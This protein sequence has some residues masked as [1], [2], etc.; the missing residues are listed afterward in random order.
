MFIWVGLIRRILKFLFFVIAPPAAVIF[1]YEAV[2]AFLLIII[3]IKV[4]LPFVAGFIGYIIADFPNHRLHKSYVAAHEL[5]HAI[6]AKLSGF[7]INKISITGTGGHV[8][9]NGK[10]KFTALAPYLIPLYALLTM[11]LFSLILLKWNFPALKIIA[12]AVFGF[13]MA[14]HL[15]NTFRSIYQEKQTDLRQGGGVIFSAILIILVNSVII[16]LSFEFLYPESI[17]ILD[18]VKS[19][20]FKTFDFWIFVIKSLF[21]LMVSVV[22]Y[23]KN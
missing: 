12:T 14:L 9:T 22:E 5:T 3:N 17:K 2:K 19:V 18:I 1:S 16:V 20:V 10:N 7:K 4:S 21:S 23:I 13:C 6:A 8:L 15:I 11:I